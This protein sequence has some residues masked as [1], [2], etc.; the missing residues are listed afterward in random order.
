MH[1]QCGITWRALPDQRAADQCAVDVK[2]RTHPRRTKSA[3]ENIMDLRGV[4]P[5]LRSKII[6]EHYKYTLDQDRIKQENM[7]NLNR[8]LYADLQN[9]DQASRMA[10]R[11][12]AS[13]AI[14]V[15][16][17]LNGGAI[18]L[19]VSFMGAMLIR[20]S[21]YLPFVPF[22][23]LFSAIKF[24]SINLCLVFLSLTL[25]Y[26]G[27]ERQVNRTASGTKLYELILSQ[28]IEKIERNYGGNRFGGANTTLRDMFYTV[29]FLSCIF[30]M[31]IFCWQ[32]VSIS[33]ALHEFGLKIKPIQATQRTIESFVE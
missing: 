5:E 3:G 14:R 25:V 21:V 7:H 16:F 19:I 28:K 30:A 33:Q 6:H 32:C 31:I 10:A 1:L 24:F 9:F 11:D 2:G 27:F 18:F 4:D 12:F 23:I 20:Q 22:D 26:L 17:L 29:A 15:S 8:M 13:Q